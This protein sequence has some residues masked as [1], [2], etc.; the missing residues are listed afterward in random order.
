[1]AIVPLQLARV[2]TLLQSSVAEQSLSSLQAQLLTVENQLSTGK[3][4]NQPSDN[5]SAASTILSLQNLLSQTQSY[6]NNINSATTQ[7]NQTESTLT[8]VS[9]L[10]TQATQKI[11]LADVNTGVTDAQRS[12]DAQIVNNLLS[13][14][15]GLAN[16]QFNGVYLFGGTKS[17]APP[18]V[19]ANGG[20]QFN[21]SNGV[22]QTT[23]GQGA[24]AP[25]Q[26]S[27]S[28]V[29]G[30]LSSRIIG[31]TDLTPSVTA[32]TQLSTL[33]GATSGGVHLGQINIS[34][35][36]GT[37]ATVDL[38]SAQTLG[39]VVNDINA[40][41]VGSIT[42]ALTT[43]GI[44]LTGA[45]S[46]NITV[47][48]NGSTTAADL[49]ILTGS[50]GAG[51]GNPVAGTALN[52]QVTQFTPLSTLLG[53][54]G[55]DASGIILTNNGKSQTIVPTSGGDVQ[56]F[57]NAINGSGLGVVAQLNSTGN[58]INLQSTVQGSNLTIG[59][60]GGATATQLGIRSF[61][62]YSE[63]S[64][65]N[66]GNGVGIE[67][68][69]TSNGDFSITATDGTKF[70]VSLAGATTVQ[71]VLSDINTAATAAG[72]SVAATLATTGN[73]IVLTDTAGGSGSLSVSP[74]NASTAAADLGLINPASST[75]TVITGADTNGIQTAG[76]F[77]DLQALATALT[78]ND[79]AGITAAGTKLQ[80]DENNV[81][82]ANA[83]AGA[84]INNLSDQTAQISAGNLATQQLLSN[85][86]DVN[87]TSAITQFQELQTA[88]QAALQVTA[89]SQST[90]LLDYIA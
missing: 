13:T 43:S 2:S 42:A 70:N 63:L 88:L 15:Q 49:G 33:G 87:I 27:A 10:L 77:S 79:L 56:S 86:Q 51:A 82:D 7:L 32:Q 8:N 76:V 3:S 19:S 69:G 67:P 1:M 58:G 38:S 83:L 6:S 21:G 48:E 22:L 64:E 46:D 60:N 90:S 12:A 57:L 84:Q 50:S 59:E 65:F 23:I 61:A 18:Y 35:G 5:P 17:N 31:A 53:G 89:Q 68:A 14:V 75:S 85:V 20:V 45:S 62:P 73:G 54:T 30:T 40:A 52:P 81:T 80:T 44:T 71:T 16:T 66:N 4:V 24:Q 9:N 26:I 36:S 47:T 28:T 39:D 11:A 74:N 78:N 34:N 37:S 72:A 25:T 55:L 41:S 29:F